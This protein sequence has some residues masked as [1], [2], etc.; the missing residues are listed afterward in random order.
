MGKKMTKKEQTIIK[1]EDFVRKVLS[2]IFNQKV[3]PETL[4]AV[5][6]KVSRAVET[7]SAKK[8]A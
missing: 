1:A 5:A 6:K 3:D 7:A 2:D 8:A 4:R